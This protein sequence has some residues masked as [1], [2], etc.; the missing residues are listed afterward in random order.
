MAK[1]G[2]GIRVRGRLVPWWQL[3]FAGERAGAGVAWTKALHE[4]SGDRSSSAQVA[5][6]VVAAWDAG[7]LAGAA[8]GE[9][10][11]FKAWAKELGKAQKRKGKRLFMPLRIALTGAMAGPDVGDILALLAL[12]DGDVADR[13]AYVALPERVEALRAWVAS[14]PAAA[15]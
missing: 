8:A 7:E 12:E 4:C 11:A 10:G 13:G 15:A 2:F 14:A 3:G 9:P 1:L 5:S 6:A